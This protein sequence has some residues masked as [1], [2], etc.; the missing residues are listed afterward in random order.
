MGS[1]TKKLINS[2]KAKNLPTEEEDIKVA[3]KFLLTTITDEW[4]LKNFSVTNID[5]KYNEIVAQARQ[6]SKQVRNGTSSNIRT[7]NSSSAQSR[8]NDA[9]SIIAR[10]SAKNKPVEG[11]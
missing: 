7:D 6:K 8:A 3:L 4:M 5:S 11:K 10:L 1:L 9:A 2:R